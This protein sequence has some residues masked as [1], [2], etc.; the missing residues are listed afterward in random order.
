MVLEIGKPAIPLAGLAQVNLLT[1]H[2][3]A[4]WV[5]KDQP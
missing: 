2:R 5:P 1:L 3:Y 4:L